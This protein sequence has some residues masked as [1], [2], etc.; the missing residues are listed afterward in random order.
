MG[1]E[2]Q[3]SAQLVHGCVP[4]IP[5]PA[6]PCPA[7]TQT[8]AAPSFG[9]DHEVT[10]RQKG[11]RSQSQ[12]WTGHPQQESALSL[13]EKSPAPSGSGPTQSQSDS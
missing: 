1:H 4:S 7:A 11:R 6:P 3:S 10:M 9:D 8:P 12:P 5:V 2:E 13:W